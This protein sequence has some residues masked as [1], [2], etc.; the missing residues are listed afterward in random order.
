[1]G[2][3]LLLT[4]RFGNPIDPRNVQR[5]FQA[6]ATKADVPAIPGHASRRTCASLLVALDVHPSGGDD[7]P[8]AQQD[9]RDDGHLQPRVVDVDQGGTQAHRQPVR[10]RGPVNPA[11]VLLWLSAF[12][13]AGRRPQGPSRV[14]TRATAAVLRAPAS[15][16][17]VA[18]TVFSE[19]DGPAA[20]W[21]TGPNSLVL[22]SFSRWERVTG[23]EPAL[24][25]WELFE[26]RGFVLGSWRVSRSRAAWSV[27]WMPAVMAR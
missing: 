21:G 24:S 23:I 11:A 8:S 27:P 2:S 14:P 12:A 22:Q 6:R 9:R 25:A 20:I 18:R 15:C 5:F 19:A 4:T 3:G 1:M 16:T 26:L 7:D 17:L 13:H 10:R